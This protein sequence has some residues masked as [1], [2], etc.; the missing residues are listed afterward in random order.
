[1]LQAPISLYHGWPACVPLTIDPGP[2]SFKCPLKV[3]LIVKSA[4]NVFVLNYSVMLVPLC[5]KGI[6]VINNSH[7]I[8]TL[9]RVK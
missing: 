3:S 2:S 7:Y 9:Q 1:M 4:C 5:K 8:K 6:L